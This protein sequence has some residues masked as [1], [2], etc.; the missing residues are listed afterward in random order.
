MK[1]VP[2][3]DTEEDEQMMLEKDARVKQKIWARATAR[4]KANARYTAR[5][6]R[7]KRSLGKGTQEESSAVSLQ[8]ED[9]VLPPRAPSPSIP[10]SS[11]P[12]SVDVSR[13]NSPIPPSHD[14]VVSSSVPEPLLP[15]LPPA[16]HQR[17][18]IQSSPSINN[19]QTDFVSAGS[20]TPVQTMEYIHGAHVATDD[21]ALL[22]R[23][24]D[25]ASAPPHSPPFTNNG[26]SSIGESSMSVSAPVWPE[27]DLY[28]YD[29]NDER[30]GPSLGQEIE[31]SPI[32]PHIPMQ[33][34]P[35]PPPPEHRII[36]TYDYSLEDIE[37]EFEPSAPPFQE[38]PN[39]PPL[40]EEIHLYATPSA[41][42]LRDDPSQS[43]YD[44][45]W[46]GHIDVPDETLT[47]AQAQTNQQT[48]ST[49]PPTPDTRQPQLV[50][51][52]AASGGL[53]PTYH[54]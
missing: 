12:S 53:L 5:Q 23:L 16:Y 38:Y 33:S 1:K 39:A 10:P 4:W 9:P 22:A 37:P 51:G 29:P 24:A 50:I 27:D 48:D 7:G 42:P 15:N 34:L 47:R 30:S 36:K 41:P 31:S 8:P 11:S 54:P 17:S 3:R 45:S 40:D 35:F 18:A 14:N 21:K 32:I 28:E 25:L 19:D 2:K 43:D 44:D 6:R 13:S 52:F 46:D 26:E 20:N 49:S